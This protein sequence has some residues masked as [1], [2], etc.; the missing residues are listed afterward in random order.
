MKKHVLLPAL[1]VLLSCYSFGQMILDHG[2]LVNQPGAGAGGADVSALHDNLNTF[3][4]AVSLANAYRLADSF[5]VPS[6]QTWHID[7]ILFYSYQTMSGTTSSTS[8][9]NCAVYNGSPAS[10]G[11]IILGDESTDHLGGTYWSGIYRTTSTT[12]TNT[13]RPIMINRMVPGSAWTLTAGTYWLSWQ[14][15]GSAS[16]TGPWAPPITEMV[17]TITGNA[18]QKT[19]TTWVA[20][21]DTCAAGSADDASQG[22]PFKIYGTV[23]TGIPD[24][25][26][27]TSVTV[28][29]NPVTAIATIKIESPMINIS[30][31]SD[32]T[33]DMFDLTGREV[34][35]IDHITK[36]E[37]IFDRAGLSNGMYSYKILYQ[38]QVIKEDKMMLQ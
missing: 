9:L 36:T 32:I 15:G 3:G 1:F 21:I 26:M 20:V 33:F 37:F 18:L 4:N 5:T 35:R 19:G 14:I 29:P 7:S 30:P 23:V 28:M 38:N 16:F 34:R 2:P 27:N 8:S 6:N 17:N 13:D 24:Y 25:T 12:F 10:A 31:A 22:F 11:T